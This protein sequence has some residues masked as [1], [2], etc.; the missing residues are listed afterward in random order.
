MAPVQSEVAALTKLQWALIELCRKPEKQ[1]RLRR[2]ILEE[3]P[4]ADPTWDELTNGTNL[5]YLDA[6]VHEVLRLHPPLSNTTRV[7]RIA[8]RMLVCMSA[9]SSAGGCGRRAPSVTAPPP[10]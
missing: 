1:A 8:F 5:V 4:A 6:V 2:E 9:H 7:V 10:A 3:F